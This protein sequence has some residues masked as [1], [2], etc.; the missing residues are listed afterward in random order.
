MGDTTVMAEPSQLWRGKVWL[1]RDDARAVGEARVLIRGALNEVDLQESLVDDAVLM[2]SEL[3][4]NAILHGQ[5]PYELVVHMDR[6][7]VVCMVIDASTDLPMPRGADARDEH[8]R[9]LLI[10]AELSIGSCGCI[11][12]R[13]VTQPGLVG[14]A[15][16]FAL[17]RRTTEQC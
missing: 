16:W 8:G 13:F 10:V 4:T 15:T 6:T 1:L 2:V 7:E 9:G 12:Q 5:A 11:P 3:V 17:P 14:K